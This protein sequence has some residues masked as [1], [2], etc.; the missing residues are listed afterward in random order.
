M[1]DDHFPP[2][3]TR[4]PLDAESDRLAWRLAVDAAG[5]G[6]FVWDLVTGELRWDDRMFELFGLAEDDFGGTIEAFNRRLHPD[7]LGRV[8]DALQRAIATC[9]DYAAEYRVVLPDGR[10][11][12]IEARGHAFADEPDGLPVRLV[13]ASYDTTDA[14]EGDARVGRVLE[15]MPSAFFQLDR[16]WHFTY[17]NSEAERL[18]GSSRVHL[19]GT[20]IW[21]A[22]PSSVGSSFET[23]YRSAV[24]SGEPVTFEAYHPAPLRAWYE[25]RA[26]PSPEGLA[27]YFVDITARRE[28]RAELDR[29]AHRLALLAS[30][31]EALTATLDP[32]EGVSRLATQ[33]VPEL[34]DWCL[35]TLVEDP[36]ATDWRRGLRDVGWSHRDPDMAQ[37]LR[38]Y[39]G[40]RLQAMTDS[41]YLA[42][43]IREMTPVLM[44]SSATEA[45]AAVLVPGVARDRLRELAPFSAVI[46]PLRARGRT[47]GVVSAFRGIHRTAFAAED[48]SLLEDIGARAALAL[49]NARL[50][51]SQRDVAE[52]LQRSILTAPPRREGLQVVTRYTPAG[53]VARIGGDW[54]DAFLQGDASDGA[55][56]VV[57]VVGDVVGHDVEAAAAMGQVRGLLRGIA[58]HSGD[59][60]AAILSG[61]DTVMESL[62]L[63]TTATAVVARFEQAP[64]TRGRTGRALLRWSHAGHPPGLL[65][66]PDGTVTRLVDDDANDL[67]LGFDPAA[68]RHEGAVALQPGATL[69][70]YTDGLVERRDRDIDDGIQSLMRLLADVCPTTSDLDELSDR[71][72][73][74]MASDEQEDDIALLV[75][76][77]A[78]EGP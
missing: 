13:G 3:T 54:Y 76:R 10:L 24:E 47:V 11:R 38:D 19:I 71:L 68:D 51:E 32:T 45:V 2:P 25:V 36:N 37:T 72:L 12:W 77:W 69:V 23:H 65:V 21:E 44:G 35:V 1:I 40:R 9:G 57:V 22:F 62:Q 63:E 78:P 67:L 56:D 8:S 33:L 18:L 7:D 43:A 75:V 50:Y 59:A 64:A 15:A 55:Q 27:V 70:L 49:D 48:V 46:V 30:V 61:L 16:D 5:V 74:S 20:A 58:V 52:A 53:D 14:R 29:S 6:V 60:P 34:A 28:A 42:E 26:W 31:S 39:A 66:D 41:S 4:S 73:E 17:V